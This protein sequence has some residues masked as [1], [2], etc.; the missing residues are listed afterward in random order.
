ML[1]A[2]TP[3]SNQRNNLTFLLVL[4]TFAIGATGCATTQGSSTQ[5]DRA[6]C[7]EL[8]KENETASVD[9]GQKEMLLAYC[10]PV[11]AKTKKHGDTHRFSRWRFQ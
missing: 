3:S 7:E 2:K 4:M 1:S 9:S 10:E 6:K 8:I 11:K 5:K